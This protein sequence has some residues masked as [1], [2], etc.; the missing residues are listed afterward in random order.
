MFSIAIDG[1]SGAGKSTFAKSLA[2]DF[3][4]IYLDTGAIY[5]TVALYMLKNGVNRKDASAVSAEFPNIEI[6]ITYNENG[7][8]EMIL[9]GENVSGMIR[10]PDVSIAASDV[11]SLPAVRAFL[12]DLQRGFAKKYNVI[13][14]GRDIGTVVLPNADLKFF[15]TASPEVR[16]K[17]RQKELF[18]KG[19][20]VD[21]ESV[22]RD[23]E[24]RDNQD[25]TRAAAPLKAAEDAVIVNTDEMDLNQTHEY[26]KAMVEE[27][28]G[29]AK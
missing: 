27:K 7:S 18:E 24:Y 20:D 16:A 4:F 23:I 26:L 17:R 9:N 22:L 29:A 19:L 1:P 2:A 3:G 10:T 14:D 21:F 25:S 12:M 5:R 28:L 6:D 8:Q 13:M 11:S 15:L